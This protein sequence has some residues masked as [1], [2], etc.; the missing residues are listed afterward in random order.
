M[1]PTTFSLL[2]MMWNFFSYTK[3]GVAEYQ[4]R[5]ANASCASKFFSDGTHF[6]AS[7]LSTVPIILAS[8]SQY[9]AIKVSL[10]ER[11][12]G[13]CVVQITVTELA[14]YVSLSRDIS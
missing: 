8:S 14:S 1:H 12:W 2:V 9:A 7:L 5:I 3:A 10:I 11:P 4:R 13:W 6:L